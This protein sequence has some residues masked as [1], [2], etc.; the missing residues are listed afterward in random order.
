MSTLMTIDTNPVAIKTAVSLLGLCTS[1]FRRP[2][3]P[4]TSE[5][6]A[7]LEACLKDFELL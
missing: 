3:V 4:L 1:E 2:L 6:L 7:T 5:K